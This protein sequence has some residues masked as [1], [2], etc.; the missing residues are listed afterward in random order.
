MNVESQYEVLVD[1]VLEVVE[2][3]FEVAEFDG[4]EFA[5]G[6]VDEH[7]EHYESG[8][9]DDDVEEDLEVDGQRLLEEEPHHQPV[10]RLAQVDH[11][12][13]PGEEAHQSVVVVVV[14]EQRKNRQQHLHQVVRPHLLYAFRQS[15]L[16]LAGYF[17]VV[18]R[19]IHIF[20]L[21]R[22]VGRVVHLHR[23]LRGVVLVEIVHQLLDFLL[24]S[25]LGA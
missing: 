22:F 7:V 9:E 12:L 1:A 20:F 11:Q 18:H 2:E 19:G 15:W 6:G 25:D 8:D 3:V 21:L 23:L 17:E 10:L 5:G 13:H 16:V 24:L 4:L 14:A